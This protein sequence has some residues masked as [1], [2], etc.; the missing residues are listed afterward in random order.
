MKLRNI[1]ALACTATL[2]ASVSCRQ[3]GPAERAG[4]S[5]DDAVENVKDAV[6][7]KGPVE[8]AG[9]KIDRALGK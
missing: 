5:L 7:P 8:K 9:E 4:E 2:A 1:L 6:Q 3:K